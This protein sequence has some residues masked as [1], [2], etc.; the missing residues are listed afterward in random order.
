[1]K[2]LRF[3]A[4]AAFLLVLAASSAPGQVCSSGSKY[5]NS[6]AC[7]PT[8][9]AGAK[10][11]SAL[12]YL[13]PTT[14]QPLSG[15]IAHRTAT[16]MAAP[17]GLGAQYASQV[18]TAPSAATSAG[19]V[20]TFENGA[21]SAKPGDLGPLVSDLPQ[22]I[23]RNRFYLGASYQWMEISKTG[24]Q[25]VKSF[26]YAKGFTDVFELADKS[27]GKN[28]PVAVDGFQVLQGSADLKI[29]N[30]DTYL[31]Y[32]VTDRLDLSVIIPFSQVSLGFTTSCKSSDPVAA[33]PSGHK[34]CYHNYVT[35]Q[36]YNGYF[37]AAY[38]FFEPNGG[39]KDASGIGDV[40]LRAK[41]EVL[42]KD[43]QGLALGIEV[44][45][46]TGDP[47]NLRGSGASGVRPFV[48]WGYSSRFSPHANLSFQYN[49][50]SVNDVVDTNP[51][52]DSTQNVFTYSNTLT[53]KKLPDVFSFSA[54]AD[55]AVNRRLNLNVDLLERVFSDD[56]S[57][58]FNAS[59]PVIPG[60]PS[61]AAPQE[62]HGNTGKTTVVLGGK[63]KLLSH[64]LLSANLLID[65]TNSGMSYKPSPVATLS[66]DFGG[67]K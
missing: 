3:S 24:G 51:T 46:P 18:A 66:Y 50:S 38:T 52:F 27:T 1:M 28:V 45:L 36:T 17:L 67:A 10:S 16:P 47:L 44:R 9:V 37:V 12:G 8:V 34:T 7:L 40:A 57:S 54:G 13:D 65:A 26:Q 60:H 15:F 58:V 23:G 5:A 6:I 56:G 63:G 4:I 62:F 43:R 11:E 41:Y 14:L 29:Q 19:Y 42:K 35:P 31:S 33:D 64:L 25:D 48:A 55:Y 32:G 21:L 61:Y 49:G 2:A 53:A 22:T 39:S 30:F 59:I 20:F